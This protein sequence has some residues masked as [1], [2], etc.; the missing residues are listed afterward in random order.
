MTDCGWAHVVVSAPCEGHPRGLCILWSKKLSDSS[1][2][3]E[4]SWEESG[5]D[6]LRLTDEQTKFWRG[7]NHKAQGRQK[8]LNLCFLIVNGVLISY[9]CAILF[10]V[11]IVSF[12]F[13]S[14]L[15]YFY[16]AGDEI[17]GLVRA[18]QVLY[19]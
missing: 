9:T 11:S 7:H 19:C 3:M 16:S 15:A 13:V 1:D 14:L 2:L 8:P 10:F 18:G 17:Q 12:L 5:Y 4:Q 6:C